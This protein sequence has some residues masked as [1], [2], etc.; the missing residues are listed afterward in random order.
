VR[1][2]LLVCLYHKG[3]GLGR[4]KKNPMVVLRGD[5]IIEV[6][7]GDVWVLGCC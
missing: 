4:M 5:G 7:R 3:G 6:R 1:V 2:L